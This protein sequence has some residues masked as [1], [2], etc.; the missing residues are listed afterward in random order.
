MQFLKDITRLFYP[1]LCVNCNKN[2]YD[3]E[4]I[5]CTSCN[6]NLPLLTINDYSNNFVTQCFYG[7]IPV[8]LG[9][10]LLA[11]KK[12]NSTQQ[13]IHDLKYKNN[14]EVGS[15]LGY[16]LGKQLKESTKFSNIDYI[17]P[18]PLHI[19]KLQQ[20][21]YNQVTTFANT[22]ANELNTKVNTQVLKR[23][24]K[25]TSQTFKNRFERF[26]D[27]NTTF[28]ITN[29]NTLIN[30]HILLVDDVITTGATLEACCNELLKTKN[31][32]ISIATI[33]FTEKS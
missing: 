17:I 27:T 13:L 25:N 33:A 30:K 15:F 18:V 3:N 26:S 9:A 16:L 29:T 12:E 2:L 20:R 7:K 4:L 14:Q 28:E 10:S 32:T 11:F 31:I 6:F 8:K 1:E 21:G 19:K 24:N 5:L 22:I 23:V